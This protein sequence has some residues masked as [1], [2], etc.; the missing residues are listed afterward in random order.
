VQGFKRFTVSI[1]IKVKLIDPCYRREASAIISYNIALVED[2]ANDLRHTQECL[3]QFSQEHDVSLKT[4]PFGCGENFLENYRSRYDIVFLDIILPGINGMETA[5]L[6]RQKDPH[7]L[8]FFLTSTADFALD[9]YEVGA[10]DYI[11]K[12]VTYY[13]L[14]MRVSSALRR[15]DTSRDIPVVLRM[16]DGVRVLNDRDIHYIEIQDHNVIYH[17]ADG[18]LSAYGTLSER[19]RELS[20]HGFVRCSSWALV[21]LR[22]IEGVYKDDLQVAGHRVHISRAKRRTFMNAFGD[23]LGR[24]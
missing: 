24:R 10:L 4:F 2:D 9:G 8:L 13:S 11:M 3:A 23:Y 1:R 6:L 17:T 19:E 16:Q 20:G 12:P 21:N 14:A 22:Y 7:V 5:K 15:I 18:D